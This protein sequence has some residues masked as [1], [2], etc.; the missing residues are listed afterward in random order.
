[1]V[2]ST[3]S[4]GVLALQSITFPPQFWDCQRA[5]CFVFLQFVRFLLFVLSNMQPGEPRLQ[6]R[7]FFFCFFNSMQVCLRSMAT[8]L[9]NPITPSTRSHIKVK[10]SALWISCWGAWGRSSRLEMSSQR[11]D[12]L[13][14]EHRFRKSIYDK[15]STFCTDL[16]ARTGKSRVK[17]VEITATA[18][19]QLWR[20][21]II[22]HLFPY[23]EKYISPLRTKMLL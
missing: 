21:H 20:N 3:V 5:A 1:M 2:G 16:T 15:K 9:Y 19:V 10:V 18:K 7:S 11:N 23:M 17:W 6:G 8:S 12:L 22:L 14:D 4:V 13:L